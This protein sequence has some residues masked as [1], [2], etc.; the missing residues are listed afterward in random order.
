[1][2]RM[3]RFVSNKD[4]EREKREHVHLLSILFKHIMNGEWVRSGEKNENDVR[5]WTMTNSCTDFMI[6]FL[7]S[8]SWRV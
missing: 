4:E 7:F 6:M 3:V 2:N 1:M 5:T 8:G